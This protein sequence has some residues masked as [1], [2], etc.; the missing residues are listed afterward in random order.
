MAG[1]KKAKQLS[2]SESD[3]ENQ[4]DDSEDYNGQEVCSLYTCYLN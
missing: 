3:E 2:K 1:A 4:S